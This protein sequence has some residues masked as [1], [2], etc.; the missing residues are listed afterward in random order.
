M[1]HAHIAAPLAAT[2]L[3][4]AAP[5]QAATAPSAAGEVVACKKIPDRD[6]RLACFDRSSDGLEAE[7]KKAVE[8][9][10]GGPPSVKADQTEATFGKHE[11]PP[12]PVAAE[13]D[14]IQSRIVSMRPDPAGRPIFTLEN[15]QVWRSQENARIHLKG[16]EVATVSR[17]MLG[18]GYQLQ[19]GDMSYSLSVVRDR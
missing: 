6:Q 3:A 7:M 10:F 2:L 13:L 16:G 15:G 12:P 11:P 17:S 14:N 8:A 18:M 9:T 4:L 19:V 1:K 5:A